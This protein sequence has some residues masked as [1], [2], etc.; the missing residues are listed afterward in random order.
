MSAAIIVP[1]GQLLRI[2]IKCSA[3][4][5]LALALIYVA[6][7]SDEANETRSACVPAVDH[8]GLR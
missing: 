3:I 2:I 5:A 1:L 4:T 7:G 6:V 8:Q